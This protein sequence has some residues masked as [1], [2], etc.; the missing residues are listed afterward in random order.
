MQVA[1]GDQSVQP[2]P[3]LT[4][5]RALEGTGRGRRPGEAPGPLLSSVM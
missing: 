3:A 2:S 5:A 4:L 1:L